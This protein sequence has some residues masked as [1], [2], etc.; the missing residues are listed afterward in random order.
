M[1]NKSNGYNN[2]I[3]YKIYLII[4]SKVLNYPTIDIIQ[5]LIE[6]NK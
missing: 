6:F 4:E 1:D 3:Y 5:W 2:Q